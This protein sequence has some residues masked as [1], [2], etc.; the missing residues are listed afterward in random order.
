MTGAAETQK[1]FPA[2]PKVERDNIPELLKTIDRWVIW[3]AGP[4]KPNGKFDK[5]PCCPATGKN[6]NG[7]DPKNWLT[8]QNALAAYD[9]GKGD[10]IGIV[11]SS[12]HPIN[13]NGTDFYLVALDFDNCEG[14][15]NEIR[16]LGLRLGKPYLEISPSGKGLRIFALSKQLLKGGNDGNGHELY[17]NGRFMTVTGWRGCGKIKDA[18][19]GLV[20]L[21]RQWFGAKKAAPKG[22]I[23][24]NVLPI[25]RPETEANI[26]LVKH[27]LS[28]VSSDTDYETWRDIVWSIIS[29]RWSCAEEIA[30]EWS[31][32]AA[33]RYEEDAFQKLVA[34]FDP[35]RGITLGT[36]HHHATLSGWVD[37]SKSATPEDASLDIK[38]GRLFADM[39]RDKL[40]FIHETGDVL[41]F[42]EVSGWVHA[43]PG[44]AD[45]AAKEV[46]KIL[47]DQAADE[48]KRNHE[49]PK[50]KRLMKHVEYSSKDSNL[51]AMIRQATSEPGMTKRLCEFDADPLLLGV[52][53]GVL[54]LN[55]GT[56]LPVSPEV[57]VSKRCN[58]AY[59][60]SA[61]CPQFHKYLDEVQ[62]V[63]EIRDFLQR[64]AGYC[65]TG[66]VGEKKFLLL[67]GTGDNGKTVFVELLNWLLGGYA[68][69]IETEMLMTHQ[70]NPQSPSADIV[71]LKG[72]RFVYANETEEGQRL[73]SARVKDMTGG[74]T[75]TGR[76][77]YG[78]APIT[79][80]PTHK[81]VIVGN[82]KPD[83]SDNSSGMWSRVGLVP[84]DE[85]ITQEKRD[86]HLLSKLKA[87]GSGILSWML[88]GYASWR[89][90]G[91]LI[92]KK[93][94]A[95]TQAY[96]DDQ[97]IIGEWK[98]EHCKVGPGLMCKK[99]EA[100]QAYRSWAQ[101]SGHGVLS[102]KRFTRQLT[103]SGVLMMPDKRSFGGIELNQ[104]GQLAARSV[105]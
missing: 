28:F 101:K 50:A 53:N 17:C 68:R 85:V 81:L 15:A 58:V 91:L 6:I 5:V 61:T 47:R 69:K 65:L 104:V 54:D 82:Y 37:L 25:P 48:W 43:E 98:S 1:T 45:R 13:L 46:A 16:E 10:G 90:Q 44:Q 14:S 29:T 22:A 3:R 42:D 67:T 57:L 66:E 92:P 99:T 21:D 87:E 95:A 79:F 38:N 105:F 20:E 74:D 51:R 77:P 62:P 23:E 76:V 30:R 55:K 26:A 2:I 60:P 102:Q 73:A 34:S 4:V 41:A 80:S 24:S 27:Q 70:R 33:D 100:Y 31:M 12:E 19:D 86:R 72:L 7:R 94:D 89:K 35:S 93:I 84:F 9:Q 49:D 11:L 96:R 83:I 75:L 97:D 56:L 40:L 32:K 52:R 63:V 59:D 8:Y 64:F 39:F 71:A 103:A 18:T 36:L 78:T 88:H